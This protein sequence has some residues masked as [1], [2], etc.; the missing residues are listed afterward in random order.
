MS[1][2]R[3][4]LIKRCIH[5]NDNNKDRRKQDENRGRLFNIR[6]LFE[7]LRQNCLSQEPEEYNSI[8]EQIIP[9]KG[10]RFLHGYMPNKS[11]K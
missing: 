4:E 11:H 8:N 1:R 5:F 9:F 10:R 3:F 6:P 2:D 7:A